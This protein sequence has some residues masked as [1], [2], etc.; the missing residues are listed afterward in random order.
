MLDRT[1][2][3]QTPEV[4]DIDM[5]VVNLIA[6]RAQE[7]A[8]HILTRPLGAA[9]RWNRNEVPGRGKL[10]IEIVIDRIQDFLPYIRIHRIASLTDSNNNYSS[11]L[12]P[13]YA[14]RLENRRCLNRLRA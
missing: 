6:A 10:N 11:A 1:K 4:I 14:H 8:D 3:A 2:A 7:V 9:G 5:P 12:R 13:R